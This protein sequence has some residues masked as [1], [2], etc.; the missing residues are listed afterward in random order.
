MREPTI[1]LSK[2]DDEKDS[3]ALRRAGMAK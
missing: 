2:E 3:D 1:Y